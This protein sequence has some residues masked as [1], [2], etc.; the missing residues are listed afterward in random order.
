MLL[1]G[2]LAVPILLGLAGYF[3]GKG[4][5]TLKEFLVHEAVVVV[6]ISVSYYVAYQG[7]MADTENWGGTIAR[8]WQGTGSCCHSYPCNPHP[9]SCDEKGNC[10]T[11]WDTCYEHGSD[12]TWEAVTSNN[13]RVYHE[14]CGRP[15]ASDPPRWTAIVVGEP[16]TVAHSYD[17]YIKGNPDSILRRQGI[18]AK[19]GKSLPTYPEVYD[20]YRANQFL[21]DAGIPDIAA[22]NKKLAEV[23]GYL[24]AAK[25]VN[26]IVVATKQDDP[27][28]LEALREHWLG[29]KKND[30]VVVIGTPRFPEIAWAGVISWTKSEEVKIA[31]RNRLLD[32]KAWNGDEVIKIV[33]EE[34]GGKFVHRPITD[35]EYLKS[36]IEP[37]SSACWTIFIIGLILAVG[38]QIY[39]WKHDPF[40]E[41]YRRHRW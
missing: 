29:G 11:C 13:E 39:F 41:E 34:V 33:R 40:H 16:T 25:E 5:V 15:G 7:R 2:L 8:K 19:Y 4:R 31:L 12:R 1:L 9:C 35:F 24:G 37:T 14:G 28:Y 20:H 3:L 32:L 18:A 22:L 38:L 36:T 23:N 30:I 21:A 26:I 10:S 17:N 27:M 6:L